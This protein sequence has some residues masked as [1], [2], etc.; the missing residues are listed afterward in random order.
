[1]EIEILLYELTS[2]LIEEDAF[3][4]QRQKIL[5]R[6]LCVNKLLDE[7]FLPLEITCMKIKADILIQLISGDLKKVAD[8]VLVINE[9]YK[10]QIQINNQKY[11]SSL[12]EQIQSVM[13]L[14]L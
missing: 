10:D 1:M 7:Y 13:D 3:Y 11:L 12:N 5:D 6:Y 2:Y 14:L 8:G 9:I 4:Q